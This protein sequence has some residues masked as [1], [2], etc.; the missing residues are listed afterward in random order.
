MK[1][2]QTILH[3]VSLNVIGSC[4]TF[5]M[6]QFSCYSILHALTELR[7][8]SSYCN[9][10]PFSVLRSLITLIALV[11]IAVLPYIS[12]ALRVY[13]IVPDFSPLLD[14]SHKISIIF[15]LTEL[16][17]SNFE[18]S[19]ELSNFPSGGKNVFCRFFDLLVT[20]FPVRQREGNF[21]RKVLTARNTSV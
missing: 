21:L 17:Y 3:E 8:M 9:W 12:P 1:R 15:F 18:M 5:E 11:V 10:Q 20:P 13:I 6:V 7:S 16:L 4:W 19:T 14:N 2:N